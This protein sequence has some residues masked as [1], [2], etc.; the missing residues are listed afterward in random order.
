MLFSLGSRDIDI[1]SYSSSKHAHHAAMVAQG[2]GS[3]ET[4]FFVE[5]VS[6]AFEGK[7]QIARHRAIN[8]LMKDEFDQGLHALSLRTKT[9]A[10]YERE[11]EMFKALKKTE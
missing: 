6:K 2:G 1:S 7:T 4:H 9:P 3:G 8:A 11:Q 10:E 5:I